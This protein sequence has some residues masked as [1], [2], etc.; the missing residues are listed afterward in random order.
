MSPNS[1]SRL[2]FREQE[3]KDPF[4]NITFTSTEN[5]VPKSTLIKK[6]KKWGRFS[7]VPTVK[8][9]RLLQI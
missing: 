6:R 8:R 5:G 9:L 2:Q 3:M 1:D 7:S 4:V